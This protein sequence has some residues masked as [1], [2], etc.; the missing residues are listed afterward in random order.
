MD[1]TLSDAAKAALMVVL[2]ENGD[3]N[4]IE[5]AEDGGSET[6]GGDVDRN[7]KI[8]D[9]EQVT[10]TCNSMYPC[11]VTV[12]NNVGT[13]VA[14]WSSMQIE[15]GMMAGVT[16]M[17][18][19]EPRDPMVVGGADRA[20]PSVV[21]RAIDETDIIQHYLDFTG[22]DPAALAAVAAP[23]AANRVMLN[24][25]MRDGDSSTFEL[26]GDFVEITA[27]G[28]G[29]TPMIK[30]DATDDNGGLMIMAG[31]DGHDISQ[32]D[33]D[34][35]HFHSLERDWSHRLPDEPKDAPLYGGFETNAL[36]ADDIE[37]NKER[38]FEKLFTLNADG[39]LGNISGNPE[40]N[41]TLAMFMYDGQDKTYQNSKGANEDFRGEF[42][43]VSGLFRCGATCWLVK[44]EEEEKDGTVTVTVSVMAD[45]GGGAPHATDF[46]TLEF[47]PD[48]PEAMASVPDWAWST[49]GAW[50]T[51]PQAMTGRH[52]IGMF[53]TGGGVANAL[54]DTEYFAKLEGTA[55]YKGVAVGYYVDGITAVVTA[56]T[57]GTFSATATL[58]ADFNTTQD[59]L[60]GTISNFHDANGMA[61]S[62]FV[63]NLDA[64]N[65]S[66]T[67][68]AA[69]T[70]SGHAKGVDW[71]GNWAGQL[72]GAPDANVE[73][74]ALDSNSVGTLLANIKDL[75]AD[76]VT[77][78]YD[79]FP[80]GATGTFDAQNA[81]SGVTGAFGAH[82]QPK[83]KE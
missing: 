41:G 52:S 46:A 50:L 40:L 76:G 17:V 8:D 5:I 70:T 10:F 63:V 45:N 56:G 29:A 4:V 68:A 77:T 35:W 83:P 6:R 22:G 37:V 58:T 59:M 67:G 34:R 66:G 39:E 32:D 11:M 49:Y 48:D 33:L 23:P 69:G 3:S 9:W 71:T 81:T 78:S 13:I 26:K 80:T 31:A 61:M 82:L 47:V 74:L 30:S 28:G 44:E 53:A 79:D 20:R 60:S 43:T 55:E 65:L 75:S 36:V 15:G 25:L 51:T 73:G 38:E 72:G 54:A 62:E 2:P 27:A 64:A 18:P 1:L 12:E 14:S 7:G 24:K 21:K 42:A 16:H 57:A 19:D